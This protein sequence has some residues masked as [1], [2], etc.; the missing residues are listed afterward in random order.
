MSAAKNYITTINM[1]NYNEIVETYNISKS[2]LT[3]RTHNLNIKGKF[4]GKVKYFT[5]AQ[6]DRILRHS[7]TQFNLHERKIVII[8]FY[9]RGMI[10]REI[11]SILGISVKMTYDAIREYNETGC[12]V[13]QSSINTRKRYKRFPDVFLKAG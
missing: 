5:M 2:A 12:V 10:G 1:M 6:V 7:P 8:E 4:V 13:V 11:A 3:H 9:N